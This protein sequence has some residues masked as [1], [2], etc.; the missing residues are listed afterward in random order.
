MEG[1]GRHLRTFKTKMTFGT[2]GIRGFSRNEAFMTACLSRH[3]INNR[4]DIPPSRRLPRLIIDDGKDKKFL[5]AL[6]NAGS[7]RKRGGETS[8]QGLRKVG[9]GCI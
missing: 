7:D 1:R 8:H 3:T 4:C 2:S 5:I 9:F 6:G